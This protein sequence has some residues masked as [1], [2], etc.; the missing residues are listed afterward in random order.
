MKGYCTCP[1]CASIPLKEEMLQEIRKAE[2]EGTNKREL[3]RCTRSFLSFPP[4]FSLSISFREKKVNWR[5][6]V[7]S[8]FFFLFSLNFNFYYFPYFLFFYFIFSFSSSISISNS[9]FFF[10]LFSFF[11]SYFSFFKIH[12]FQAHVIGEKWKQRNKGKTKNNNKSFVLV[13]FF[14]YFFPIFFYFFFIFFF[15]FLLFF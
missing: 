4:H 12:L 3:C 10:S 1:C 7:V 11:F 8:Y 5:L 14:P 6:L 9:I 13:F 2:A 15:N